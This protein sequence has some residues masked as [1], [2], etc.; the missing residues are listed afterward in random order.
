MQQLAD[1]AQV[2]AGTIYRYFSDKNEFLLELKRHVYQQIADSMAI[3]HDPQD[4]LFEQYRSLWQN[5]FEFFLSHSDCI[6]CLLQ[7]DSSPNANQE[8]MHLFDEEYF[9]P[10]LSFYE[11]GKKQGVFLDL[12]QPA[13]QALSLST[14]WSAC[15]M[16][17]LGYV[18]FDEELKQQM[19]TASWKAIVK[20]VTNTSEEL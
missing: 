7:F 3:G 9:G 6:N 17:H 8:S 16:Q 20:P 10:V 12:P 13:L 14:V 11:A 18:Q 2:A 4:P 5:S 1:R 15:K 19:I